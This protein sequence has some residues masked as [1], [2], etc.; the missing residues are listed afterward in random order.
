MSAAIRLETFDDISPIKKFMALFDTVDTDQ[1]GEIHKDE[2]D[3]YLD[4]LVK[5]HP[6]AAATLEENFDKYRGYNSEG[7]DDSMDRSEMATM[8]VSK[9]FRRVA[10]EDGLLTKD[11]AEAL[12]A[13]CKQPAVAAE[14]ERLYNSC[15]NDGE[16]HL[17]LVDAEFCFS[18]AV[19]KW[20]E[21]VSAKNHV[22]EG[23]EQI[24]EIAMHAIEEVE[25]SMM[26]HA[27]YKEEASHAEDE[28]EA[29]HDQNAITDNAC[30]TVS[31]NGNAYH[32]SELRRVA[33][34]E[35]MLED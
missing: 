19:E 30:T 6:E 12:I 9:M 21:N 3:A 17:T 7:D 33:G 15:T 13:N 11:E 2:A 29:P 27:N 10:G 28:E 35:Y 31:E 4:E 22:V 24:A 32:L 8:S 1:N 14:M 34:D 18:H 20:I 5:T 16:Y 25:E 23:L 26:S